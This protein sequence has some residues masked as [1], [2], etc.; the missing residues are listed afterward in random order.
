[1]RL[2]ELILLGLVAWTAIGVV[3]STVAKRRGEEARFRRG[4]V[5]ICGGWTA[6]L[7]VLLTVS[8]VQ[9]GRVYRP[10]EERCFQTVCFAVEGA[11]EVEGFKARGQERERLL[12]VRVRVRNR[13]REQAA[14][15]DDLALYLADGQGRRWLPVPGLS[16][17]PLSIRVAPGSGAVSTPVFRLAKDATGLRLVLRHTHWT[18]GRLEIGGA[19]SWLHRPAE[20]QI[21]TQ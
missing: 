1:M 6:Y 16:G 19:E 14:S 10:K 11:D 9:G 8:L 13:G 7:G 12:R 17:V 21:E 2:S 3:G 4:Y 5:V 15:E 20:M 18:L